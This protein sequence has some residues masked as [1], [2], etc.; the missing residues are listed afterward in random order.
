VRETSVVSIILC[1]L[2]I[3]GKEINVVGMPL[4]NLNHRRSLKVANSVWWCF[5]FVFVLSQ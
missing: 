3:R 2:I 5:C 1:V 4:I